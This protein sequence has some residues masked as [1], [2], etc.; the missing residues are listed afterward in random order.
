M[1]KILAVFVL[2]SSEVNGFTKIVIHNGNYYYLQFRKMFS[3]SI[4]K[5]C[6]N[7]HIVSNQGFTFGIFWFLY[8]RCLIYVCFHVCT[9]LETLMGYNFN[10]KVFF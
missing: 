8:E 5:L 7:R 2:N 9:V 4:L 3:N 1:L 6:V 10:I